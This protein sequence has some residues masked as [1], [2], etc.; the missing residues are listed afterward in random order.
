MIAAIQT[1]YA[2]CH[3]RSRLEA[4]WAVFFDTLNIK[5]EYEKEGFT[6]GTDCYLPDF[7]L[8]ATKT[9]VEVK[10]D[11]DELKRK[12]DTM[13]RLLDFRPVLP[14]FST[15][16]GKD[17]RFGLILLG[18]IPYP[19]DEYTTIIEHPIVRHDDGLIR[20]WCMF[21]SGKH[22]NGGF[23]SPFL[24]DGF[25]GIGDGDSSLWDITPRLQ[26]N[27]SGSPS[28]QIYDTNVAYLTARA[29]RFEFE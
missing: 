5:W 20:S 1:H 24:T 16:S 14:Y 15:G 26:H 2:G 13:Y 10:G 11:P 4:R 17:N 28:P 23:G 22:L 12:S 7:Y 18:N 3:F 6:N 25:F 27:L 29:K 19:D 8:P 21:I 9:W